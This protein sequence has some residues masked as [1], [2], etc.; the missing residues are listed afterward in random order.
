MN[1]AYCAELFLGDSEMWRDYSAPFWN[2]SKTWATD[3]V[4][5]NK[6]PDSEYWYGRLF[7]TQNGNDKA[8]LKIT[9]KSRTIRTI[10]L[11]SAENRDNNNITYTVSVGDTVW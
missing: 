8:Y 10:L 2:S 11:S 6:A 5:T 7:V 3:G 1:I 9:T 4:I